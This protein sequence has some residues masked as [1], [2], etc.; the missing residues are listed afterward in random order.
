MIR[1]WRFYRIRHEKS[2][3]PE[4][5]EMTVAQM[6]EDAQDPRRMPP[7][8]DEGKETEEEYLDLHCGPRTHRLNRINQPL[9]YLRYRNHI[10]GSG[11]IL[12]SIN[13]GNCSNDRSNS[14]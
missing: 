6:W 13:L 9:C 8:N 11:H 3:S 14:C 5:D 10:T 1:F 4:H 2:G 7:M 12:C